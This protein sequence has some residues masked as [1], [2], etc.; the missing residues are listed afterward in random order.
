MKP[1]TGTNNKSEDSLTAT[2]T[3][4][5][6]KDAEGKAVYVY[7]ATDEHFVMI[8]LKA[9]DGRGMALKSGL[10]DYNLLRYNVEEY[11]TGLNLLTE[12]QGIVIVQKFSNAVFAKKYSN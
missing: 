7:N 12:K 1:A 9:F 8:F 10:S 6:L 2:E 4:K 5:P 3:F 11:T